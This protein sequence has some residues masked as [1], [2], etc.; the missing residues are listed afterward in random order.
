MNVLVVGY[1]S[2]GKRHTRNL[3]ELD[4]IDK[5]TVYTK[6]RN[7]IN[8]LNNDKIVFIDTT[9]IILNDLCNLQRFDFAII[10]NETYKHVDTAIKLAQ[11]NV[12][13]FIEKP[14]SHNIE[15]IDLLNA[16]V[17]E[18][19]I[20]VF[21]AYNLRFL[22]AIQFIKKQLKDNKIGKLYFAKIEAGQY[23]PSWRP[24]SDYKN[25][26]SSRKN[27]GGGVA[28]DLS[29]E[30]DYMR[31]LFGNPRTWHCIK[32][33]VS[34]LEIDSDD[35]FEGVYEY[36]DGLV[37]N[38]HMDYLQIDKK[39]NIRI[40]G[41]NGSIECDLIHKTIKMNIIGQNQFVVDDPKLFDINQTY[42]D[43]LVSFIKSMKEGFEPLVGLDE[44][45]QVIR[46]IENN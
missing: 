8:K 32:K 31:Y 41:S 45:I 3:M 30:I 12:N 23:L 20:K 9:K 42:I 7:D 16:I 2:I 21:V 4:C 28:L 15:K 5:I 24:D 22:G 46:L 40:I 19:K 44:G 10:A 34:D 6:L 14:L 38:V 43:E 37:C 27:Y 18:N 35:L 26:Y 29:H 36:A 13:L 39:R 17:R 33:K 11:Q 1:G 25:S